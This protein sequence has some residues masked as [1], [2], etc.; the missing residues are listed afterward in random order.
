MTVASLG[1]FLIP[2]IPHVW[3]L[4]P[5]LIVTQVPLGAVETGAN[6]FLLEV[7]GSAA[8]AFLQSLQLM[9]G[10]GALLAPLLLMPFLLE[11]EAEEGVWLSGDSLTLDSSVNGTE[12]VTADPKDLQLVYPF[13]VAAACLLM[14]AAY[15]TLLWHISPLTSPHPSKREAAAKQEATSTSTEHDQLK[16]RFTRWKRVTI[17]LSLLFM[18]V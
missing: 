15:V 6:V 5:L 16:D 12:R 18:H 3:L 17:A 7:W 2:F 10:V 14:S 9:F 4:V 8:G 13:S 1:C 11:Q